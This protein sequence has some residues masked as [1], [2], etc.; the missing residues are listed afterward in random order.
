VDGS[1]VLCVL[2]TIYFSYSIIVLVTILTGGDMV[3]KRTKAPVDPLA[4]MPKNFMIKCKC[5]WA[6]TSTGVKADLTD[7]H[8]IKNNTT[9]PGRFRK[10][11]CP[12][13]GLHATM[14]RIKI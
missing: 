3:K 6:R 10:F 2:L 5:G 11:A 8:E 7:L 9:V 4:G 14:K 12:K 1:Y 13:C